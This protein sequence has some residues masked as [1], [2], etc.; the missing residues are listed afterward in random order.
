MPLN[1]LHGMNSVTAI[2][3]IVAMSSS[4]PGRLLSDFFPHVVV[5]AKVWSKAP[6]IRGDEQYKCLRR[7]VVSS[8]CH[9]EPLNSTTRQV[10]DDYIKRKSADAGGRDRE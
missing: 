8:K 2:T 5:I 6:S 10:S 4:R 7:D 3:K 9:F 1:G